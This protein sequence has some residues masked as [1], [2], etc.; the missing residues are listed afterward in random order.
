MKGVACNGRNDERV[1]FYLALD[2][3]CQEAGLDE[4]VRVFNRLPLAGAIVTK[5]D[6]AAQLG[7]VLS[8]LIR[9]D[10]PAAFLSDGQRVPD[11]LHK[12]DKK[13]LWLVNQAVECM[14]SSRIRINEETMV[15][16]FGQQ[17]VA[18]G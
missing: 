4:T 9:H 15:H 3:T 13:R 2:A 16:R 12:A 17:G 5:I 1:H 18:H 14:R 8:T 7:C 11:D 6:E 10:L